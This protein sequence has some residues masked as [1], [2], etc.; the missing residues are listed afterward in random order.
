MPWLEGAPIPHVMTSYEIAD[1][2]K[3]FG[4]AA[5]RIG[6]AGLDGI[7]IHLG[8]GHLLHQFLS[9]ASN[10]RDDRYGGGVEGRVR[11]PIDILRVIRERINSTLALGIRVSG[12]DFHANGLHVDDILEVCSLIEAEVELDFINVSQSAYVGGYSLSTQIPDSHFGSAPFTYLAERFKSAF[13]A[14]PIMSVG[15]IDDLDVAEDVLQRGQADMVGMTRA[16]ISD[17]HIIKKR[18]AGEAT[19]SCIAC[20]EGCVGQTERKSTR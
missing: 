15:R 16:H 8:H 3:A 12:D 2:G 9:P 19:R 1:L 5:G 13:P 6:R 14:T 18:W 7:E 11:L 10:S 20:N 17:P 4:T